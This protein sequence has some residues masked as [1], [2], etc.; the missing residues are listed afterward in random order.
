MKVLWIA[1]LMLAATAGQVQAG[2]LSSHSMVSSN[3]GT[4]TIIGEAGIH[5][6]DY[7]FEDSDSK[8][9]LYGSFREGSTSATAT[10]T[11]SFLLHTYA[12][13]HTVR[14]FGYG[15]NETT[16]AAAGYRDVVTVVNGT[17]PGDLRLFFSLDGELAGGGHVNGSQGLA[18]VDVVNYVNGE[19]EFESFGGPGIMGSP[20]AADYRAGYDAGKEFYSSFNES[21]WDSH[22]GGS[23][24]YHID[25]PYND[26]I[27]GYR[28]A[29]ILVST[30]IASAS[31]NNSEAIAISDFAHTLQFTGLSLT[32]GT[33]L[34]AA[35]FHF[36]SGLTFSSTAVPEP[37]SLAMWGFGTLCMMFARRK[38]QQM[39]LA[40]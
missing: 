12:D 1:G 5:F 22:S 18:H 33:P 10:L 8:G 20:V 11:P 28:F 37:A 27:G 9:Y 6:A 31:P 38:R 39:K 35:N 29:T 30:A 34:D 40:A 2:F 7:E 3:I 16:A 23:Y 32:D 4:G 24:T 13:A 26:R 15:A 36:D 19:Y 21:G 25:V 14:N 17:A